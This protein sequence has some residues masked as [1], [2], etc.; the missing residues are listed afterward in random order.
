MSPGERRVDTDP[1]SLGHGKTNILLSKNVDLT[2]F[3]LPRIHFIV[4]NKV[5]LQDSIT[6]R[7][8]TFSGR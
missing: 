6:I 3:H 7:R 1:L 2:F 5:A 8:P 4:K